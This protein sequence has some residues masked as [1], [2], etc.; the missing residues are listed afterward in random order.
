MSPSYS[1]LKRR[2]ADHSG[3]PYAHLCASERPALQRRMT[4]GALR[5]RSP[6]SPKL[7][8]IAR[9]SAS[10]SVP[11]KVHRRT[12]CPRKARAAAILGGI[13]AITAMVTTPVAA[14]TNSTPPSGAG[15]VAGTIFVEDPG[16]VSG[17]VATGPGSVTLYRP[18]ATAHTHPE[19]IVTKGM[20]GPGGIALDSSGDLWVANEGGTVVEYSRAALAEASPSP[21]VT[22][23]Y[24]GG[25]LA[26]DSA[27]NLWVANG[28]VVAEF[29]KAQIA[30]SGS[31]KP[32][33]ALADS[34]SVAFDPYGDMWVGSTG[35]TVSEFTKAQ[36]AKPGQVSPQVVISS[37]DLNG[38]CK[39][40]FDRSGDLWAGNY[41]T[42]LVVEFTKSQ[43]AKTA[44]LAPK[45]A[46]SSVQNGN[47][48]D[49]A[50]DASGD[51][52]VPTQEFHTVVEYT[53][54]QLA[55]SGSPVPKTT[56]SMPATPNG[57]WGVAIEP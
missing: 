43:L 3:A 7:P 11:K 27:G 28:T 41:N 46:I 42:S 4:T 37:S 14:A 22:L 26:F 5:S 31:P 48:G 13:V 36:L 8:G 19:V 21:T 29:T 18:G 6:R 40:A 16:V 17:G 54:A 2:G 38:P 32:V 49:V 55:K 35:S 9:H 34:C 1:D 47:P 52:W 50:L 56:I 23:S 45:V 25:G 30:R 44:T 39:P 10:T 57:P 12:R 53:K 51:L 33:R 15:P 20:D 24:G